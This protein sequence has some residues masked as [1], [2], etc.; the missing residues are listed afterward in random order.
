MW[1]RFALIFAATVPLCGA[2][3]DAQADAAA[4]G[5]MLGQQG[6]NEKCLA[7]EWMPGPKAIDRFNREAEPALRAYL[8]LATTNA[9]P[10]PSFKGSRPYLRWMLDGEQVADIATIRDPWAVHVDR[11]EQVELTLGRAGN[12]GRGVWCAYAADGA[13]LGT[14]YVRLAR[15]TKGY[16]VNWVDLWSPG[17]EHQAKPLTPFCA[18][19]GDHEDWLEAKDRAQRE[20]EARRAKRLGGR[21]HE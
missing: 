11:L 21:D 16:G 4:I 7:L 1:K 20:K 18:W 3:A 5:I 14:Y 9:D 6:M 8:D 13:F 15:K 17:M 12:Y 10:T 19:P 2:Q